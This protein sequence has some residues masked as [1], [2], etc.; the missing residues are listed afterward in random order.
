V[1]HPQGSFKDPAW[2]TRNFHEIRTQFEAGDR[3]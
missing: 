3:S 1:K 2:P